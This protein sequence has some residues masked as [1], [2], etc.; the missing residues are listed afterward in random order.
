[1]YDFSHDTS[2]HDTESFEDNR[3]AQLL[4][5]GAS[6]L[7]QGK[8]DAA[9]ELLKRALHQPDTR[10]AAHN[11]IEQHELPG[12]FG[13]MMAMPCQI[14]PEDDIFHFF[15]GHPTSTNPLRDYLADGWRTLSELM[16]L[17]EAVNRPLLKTRSFLEFASGHG[18]FTRHLVKALGS[19][20]VTVSDV[21]PGAVDFSRHV[22]GVDGFTSTSAPEDIAWPQRY[23]VV[24]V[25]SLFSH[26]PRRTWARWLKRLYG[27]VAPGG[28]LIFTTHG[29]RATAFDKVTLDDEGFFFAPSSESNAIDRFEYGTTFTSEA[30][31][32]ARIAETVGEECLVHVAPVQFWNHQDAYVLTKPL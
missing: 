26:L 21:V 13:D 29:A 2:N 12:A 23:D 28:V 7:D 22:F 32:R 11:L 6:L 5:T 8:R 18:R 17:L 16:L 10:L 30:F 19:Q 9:A 4:E 15:A 3:A 1:M 20:R 24:F 27:A 14:A 31:V 25:L